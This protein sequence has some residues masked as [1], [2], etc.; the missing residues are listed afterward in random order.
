MMDLA[1]GRVLASRFELRRLL[2]RGGMGQVWLALDAELGEQVAVK[3]LEPALAADEAMLALLRHECRQAR[4]LVH[5]NIVRVYDFHGEDEHPFISME[6]VEGGELGR[7]RDERPEEILSL[8]LPLTSALAYAHGQGI[9]HR[10]LKPSNILID[11][12]GRP[13]LVDFGVAGLLRGEATIRVTGGGSPHSMSPQQ[14][15]GLPPS[16]AD[17]AFALG[18]LIYEL[19]TGFPPS[20]EIGGPPAPAMRSRANYAVPRRLQSVVTR[21]LVAEAA[22]RPADMGT[23]GRDLESALED[24]RNRTRPPEVE[25]VPAADESAAIMPVS[26]QPTATRP[27]G[28]TPTARS[29]L[30]VALWVAF[31]VLAVLLLAVVFVLPGYVQKDR[32]DRQTDTPVADAPIQAEELERLASVKQ[33]ADAAAARFDALAQDL[34]ARGVE[35]WGGADFRDSQSLVEAARRAYESVQY[36]TARDTWSRAVAMLESLQDRGRQLLEA[37]LQRGTAALEDGRRAA[38]EREFAAALALDPGNE[39]AEAGL[40]RAEK[41]EQVHH[42]FS[43]GLELEEDGKLVEARERFREAQALDPQFRGPTEAITRVES[44]MVNRDYTMAMSEAYAALTD[45]RHDDAIRGFERAGR[46]RPSSAEP[47]AGI[48]RAREEKRVAAIADGRRRAEGL[49]GQERWQEAATVYRSILAQDATV[50]FAQ[51]G[52]RKAAERAELDARLQAFIDDS[53][54]MYSEQVQTAARGALAEAAAVPDPGPRLRRQVAEVEKLL[55]DAMRP[56]RVV[57][58][59]DNLTEIVLY[60][61]GRLGTFDRYQLEL[62]PGTYTVVGTRKGFRDVR[63]Q[64]TVRPGE[65]AGPYTVRCEEPI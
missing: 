15:A 35:E 10:D 1:P 4:R 22:S 5:P 3:V 50:A 8:V 57:L 60:K 21:L 44:A 53:Q 47:P 29:R 14:R 23:I 52:S 18:V 37:S 48:A 39:A 38:A 27:A 28:E 32:V 24:L 56:V 62:R 25:V 58:E 64:F 12:E 55:A 16:P 65:P 46:I 59:S 9:V 45:G 20:V 7:F 61:I 6:F 26:R 13:R 34:L 49:E 36:E 54:R 63:Q 2:G 40:A 31:G 30:P 17:D 42:L 43:E 51:A 19:I 33:E 11:R 41:I